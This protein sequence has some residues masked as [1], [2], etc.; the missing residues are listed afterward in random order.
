ME[1]EIELKIM[2]WAEN[3]PAVVKWFDQQ[4]ILAKAIEQLGNSYYDFDDLYFAKNKM[5][6]RVRTQNDQ[7][8]MTLKMAGNIV[9]GLHIR[10][11][12]NLKLSSPVPDFKQFILH[13]NLS[14]D[15]VLL[16]KPLV[17]IFS[18]DFKRTKWLV[19]FQN[20]QIEIALDQGIIKNQY[21]QESICEIEFELKQGVLADLFDLLEKM[22]KQDGM[23]LSSLS[24]AQRGYLVGNQVKITQ[25]IAKLIE[26]VTACNFEKLTPMEQYQYIQQIA[27]FIR[28]TQNSSLIDLYTQ[29]VEIDIDLFDDLF[30]KNTL[31]KQIQ[32]MKSLF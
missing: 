2:L 18:T 22:P 21:G 31:L 8:E 32:L 15:D 17:A 23:W 29:W 12:Y 3:V 7:Y 24:K 10:P 6:L 4:T 5:G 13:H 14:F 20:S 9:G 16:N 30:S 26:N 25:E 27:D 28:L 19:H 11:E 1:N